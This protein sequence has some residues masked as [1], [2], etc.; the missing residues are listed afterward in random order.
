MSKI[1]KKHASKTAHF[2]TRKTNST[3][4]Y[5]MDPAHTT[6]TTLLTEDHLMADSNKKGEKLNHCEIFIRENIFKIINVCDFTWTFF[7]YF[8]SDSAFNCKK[9][10][11][12]HNF[13]HWFH[14]SLYK[15]AQALIAEE[16]F[17]VRYIQ[18]K[19]FWFFLFT[20]FCMTCSQSFLPE[21][22]TMILLPFVQTMTCLDPFPCYANTNMLK[23]STTVGSYSLTPI[24]KN[25]PSI[26]THSRQE[27]W[28]SFQHY[29][30]IDDICLERTLLTFLT[31]RT[32]DSSFWKFLFHKR[33][34]S[35]V[36]EAIIVL[37]CSWVFKNNWFLSGFY[38]IQSVFP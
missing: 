33:L 26:S 14:N 38:L 6:E 15:R 11:L 8:H 1:P 34:I 35:A 22:L 24:D 2:W 21:N 19:R 17:P 7:H 32:S 28:A 37:V 9:T 5:L 10:C 4:L 29:L 16:L 25:I 12:F 20:F 31:A 18:F 36:S 23:Y 13:L 27:Y 30:S 3:Q